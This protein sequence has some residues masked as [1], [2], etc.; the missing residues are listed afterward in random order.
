[1]NKPVGPQTRSLS[2]FYK[3][4]KLAD[5]GK[6]QT[7]IFFLGGD[8]IFWISDIR[9][10]SLWGEVWIFICWVDLLMTVGFSIENPLATVQCAFF[11]PSND[12]FA[13]GRCTSLTWLGQ[14]VVR[15]VY[16]YVGWTEIITFYFSSIIHIDSNNNIINNNYYNYNSYW[17]LIVSLVHCWNYHNTFS[18][19]HVNNLINKTNYYYTYS[20]FS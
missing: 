7:K 5:I 20:H 17:R 3:K 14:L 13:R 6:K 15:D 9:L 18:C 10:P 1:M 19:D 11:P 2:S 4:P 8:N 16:W 12:S